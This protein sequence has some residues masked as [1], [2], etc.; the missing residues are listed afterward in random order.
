MKALTC[1]LFMFQ[2]VA[3]VI[4]LNESELKLIGE[5]L[6]FGNFDIHLIS[7]SN[8]GSKDFIQ[9]MKMAAERGR[10]LI[11][12]LPKVTKSNCSQQNESKY[13]ME[14]RPKMLLMIHLTESHM[15]SVLES[16]ESSIIKCPLLIKPGLF[17]ASN[18]F[19]NLESTSANKTETEFGS[20]REVRRHK[21][22]NYIERQ[23]ELFVIYSYNVCRQKWEV[24]STW[25]SN[26]GEPLTLFR[27]MENLKDCLLKVGSI[28]YDFY[29]Y[30][31]EVENAT[32][33][34][35]LYSNRRGYDIN[36]LETICQRIHC[37]ISYSNPLVLE[38]GRI[39]NGSFEGLVRDVI[40]EEVDIIVSVIVVYYYRSRVIQYSH[41]FPILDGVKFATKKGEET[42]NI[43]ILL[44]VFDPRIWLLY[45]LSLLFVS[46]VLWR[47]SEMEMRA[48]DK[49]PWSNLR[50]SLWSNFSLMVGDGQTCDDKIQKAW[51]LR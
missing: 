16:A 12:G 10:T 22:A 14:K 9:L 24:H 19:V 48:P 15:K 17:Q 45:L 30:A 23:K 6:Q 13:E 28:P 44:E 2:A 47:I 41:F 42:Q 36:I 5:I 31:D 32:N 37:S 3:P 25:P 43:L 49:T 29:T 11:N 34:R 51:G 33:P 50:S 1:L 20:H 18:M 39:A 7:D 35:E 4:S 46:F 26:G 27:G 38:W 21:M 8:V 40:E